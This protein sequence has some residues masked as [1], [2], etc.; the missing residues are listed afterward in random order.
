[1]GSM[2]KRLNMQTF[3]QNLVP[4]Y[5]TTKQFNIIEQSNFNETRSAFLI[6]VSEIG[7]DARRLDQ[8]D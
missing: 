6:Y 8:S 1:M 3:L 2:C 5:F 4:T 7:E